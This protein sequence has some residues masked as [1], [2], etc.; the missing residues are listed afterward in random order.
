[1]MKITDIFKALG[2]PVS[3]YR[4][5]AIIPPGGRLD[6]AQ[7]LAA[8]SKARFRSEPEVVVIDLTP[9]KS[10]LTT[11]DLD[12]ETGGLKSNYL[13]TRALMAR[14]EAF[15]KTRP[16]DLYLLGNVRPK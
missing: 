6:E 1:M 10:G 12:L 2:F 4:M 8:V 3:S 13:A 7:E 14:A 16:K 11:S 15:E 9:P 5:N